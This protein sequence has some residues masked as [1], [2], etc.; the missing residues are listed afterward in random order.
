MAYETRGQAI[1]Q[2]LVY[3]YSLRP[4]WNMYMTAACFVDEAFNGKKKNFWPRDHSPQVPDCQDSWIIR[5]QI[6]GILLYILEIGVRRVGLDAVVLWWACVNVVMIKYWEFPD[7]LSNCQLSEVPSPSEVVWH[8]T[9]QRGRH[10]N[11]VH[12]TR[13]E[14]YFR[15]FKFHVET[16]NFSWICI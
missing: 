11:T 1:P 10:L 12:S 15:V 9:P 5:R 7:Q 3:R 2:L 6:K 14:Q 13:R 8:L 4:F 16:L